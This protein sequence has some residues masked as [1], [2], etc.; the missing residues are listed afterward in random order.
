[1]DGGLEKLAVR[2]STL[3]QKCNRYQSLPVEHAHDR[4]DRT[5]DRKGLRIH[6]YMHTHIHAHSSRAHAHTRDTVQA[7]THT[8]SIHTHRSRG[9][10]FGSRDCPEVR[11]AHRN[12]DLPSLNR[13]R[14][15]LPVKLGP[16]NREGR[17]T[18]HKMRAHTLH[19]YIY[20]YIYIWFFLFLTAP[21]LV[22]S[23]KEMRRETNAPKG[24]VRK[25]GPPRPRVPCTFCRAHGPWEK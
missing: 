25:P 2:P 12:R 15:R 9:I 20:I 4:D 18:I 19:A 7:Y 10:H 11:R 24:Y 5:P 1:M 8:V 13:V 14:C 22:T 23:G 17:R 16:W 6:I 21:L 3:S